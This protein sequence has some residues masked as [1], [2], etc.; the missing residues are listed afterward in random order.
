[1][2]RQDAWLMACKRAVDAGL[3]DT[4]ADAVVHRAMEIFHEEF[5]KREWLEFVDQEIQ[6]HAQP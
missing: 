3:D 1:M 5:T 2:S 4:T 6:R